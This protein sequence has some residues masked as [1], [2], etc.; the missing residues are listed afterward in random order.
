MSE[1]TKLVSMSVSIGISV[2]IV[3]IIC[4]KM[5][6]FT[7]GMP[8]YLFIFGAASTNY[9]LGYNAGKTQLFAKP[10]ASNN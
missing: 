5:H 9:C 3:P 6:L 7:V 10:P 8:A 4:D 1:Q 2:L